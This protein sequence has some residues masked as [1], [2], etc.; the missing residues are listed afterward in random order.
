[1]L[2]PFSPGV[3]SGATPGALA[4]VAPAAGAAVTTRSEDDSKVKNRTKANSCAEDISV[5]TLLATPS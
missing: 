4:S 3:G 1:M 2:E 5:V